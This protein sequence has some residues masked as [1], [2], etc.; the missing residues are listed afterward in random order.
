MEIFR[1]KNEILEQDHK[2]KLPEYQSGRLGHMF[3]THVLNNRPI[4]DKGIRILPVKRVSGD[5]KWGGWG[6]RAVGGHS[7]HSEQIVV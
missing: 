1:G 7:P 5:K 6:G 2:N 4:T 3:T